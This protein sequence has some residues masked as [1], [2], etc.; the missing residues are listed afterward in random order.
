M[1]AATI[2]RKLEEHKAAN[3]W[4]AKY[5]PAFENWGRGKLGPSD[6]LRWFES[7]NVIDL[8]AVREILRKAKGV[9]DDVRR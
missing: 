4:L 1:D 6:G 7:E 3:A 8:N 2:L 5:Q 9:S